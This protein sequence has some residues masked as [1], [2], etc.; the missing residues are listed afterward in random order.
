MV[1]GARAGTKALGRALIDPRRVVDG[2][3]GVEVAA[4]GRVREDAIE[5]SR[6]ALAAAFLALTAFLSACGDSSGGEGGPASG[7]GVVDADL[8]VDVAYQT[9]L[10]C[11]V[12]SETAAACAQEWTA[13]KE[14]AAEAGDAPPPC[15][16][17][18]EVDAEL[19][20]QREAWRI[21]THN[22]CWAAFE[23][24]AHPDQ[25]VLDVY[26]ELS[27]QWGEGE[28]ANIRLLACQRAAMEWLGTD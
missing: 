25:V 6:A 10:A 14:K 13:W 11:L 23:S 12:T 2:D 18:D 15:P 9:F 8:A 22:A 19:E 26:Q 27:M 28:E 7:T 3:H 17:C 4:F 1:R 24:G 5:L 20:A 21:E 16:T